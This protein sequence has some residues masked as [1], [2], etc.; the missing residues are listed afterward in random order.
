MNQI[1]GGCLCGAIRY[2]CN[3][4]PILQAVCQ[5]RHCQRQTGTAL[6]VLVAVPKGSLAFTQGQPAT[7]T[8][9]GGSGLP[10]H[11][12]FCAACGSPIY[13]DVAATPTMDWVK[14]GTLDDTA[15]LKP[16]FSIWCESEQAWAAGATTGMRRFPQNPPSED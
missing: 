3:A 2:E 5:C 14:A 8:H 16:Q 6:S 13:S 7:Y 12:R 11:R 9:T 10:V 15:W 4:A 1:V